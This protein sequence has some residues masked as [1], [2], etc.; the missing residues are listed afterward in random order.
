MLKWVFGADTTPFRRGLDEMRKDTKAFSGSI[1]GYIAGAFAGGAMLQFFQSMRGHAA[2]I[3]DLS[4]RFG[5]TTDSIERVSH[6][7]KLAGS[8]MEGIA[9]ALTVVT[10]NAVEASAGNEAMAESF[11]KLGINAETFA[12]LGVE[13]KLLVL[14]GAMD[15]GKNSAENMTAVMRVMGKSGAEMMP[16]LIQGQ[17]ELQKQFEE[18]GL[19]GHRTINMLARF[20]DSM[21]ELKNTAMVV[22]SRIAGGFE[23]IFKALGAT[24]GGA[25][26]IAMIQLETLVAVAVAA[27]KTV[28]KALTGDF[29]GAGESAG[30]IGTAIKDGFKGAGQE[31]TAAK[32]LMGET[33]N[34]IFDPQAPTP[35]APKPAAADFESAEDD[36]TKNNQKSAAS[37]SNAGP[38]G[39]TPAEQELASAQ[40]DWAALMREQTLAAMPDEGKSKFLKTERNESNATAREAMKRGDKLGAI[41]AGKKSWEIQGELDQVD[42]RI[43]EKRESGIRAGVQMRSDEMQQLGA[44]RKELEGRGPTIKA[45]ALGD[46]GGGGGVRLME[47]DYSS[48]LDTIISRMEALANIGLESKPGPPEPI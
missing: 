44:E 22:A 36:T 18:T 14:A 31:I 15:K 7:A 11:A 2:R 47:K 20:D 21:D 6:A 35:A 34:E 16:L 28:G 33:M 40:K 8:D 42:G 10:R 12:T 41:N 9:K 5:E 24:I 19:I 1:K 17:E 27:G 26:G 48:K 38:A 39:P 46:I 23:L 37:E 32:E 25:V 45:S 29:K 13:E 43:T 3:K 4:D 30:Q